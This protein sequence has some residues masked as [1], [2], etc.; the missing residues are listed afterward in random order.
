NID[1]RLAQGL[2]GIFAFDPREFLL[3][4]FQQLADPFEQTTSLKGGGLAPV[5]EGRPGGLDCE[6]NLARPTALDLRDG[7]AGAG[8][9]HVDGLS[10]LDVDSTAV[11]DR[12]LGAVVRVPGVGIGD[13]H[14]SCSCSPLR[15]SW[16]GWGQFSDRS[17]LW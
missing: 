5:G 3:A 12:A 2:P 11:D 4:L 1:S 9:K 14:V 17:V 10:V 13:S 16:C 6:V 8:V 7:L 15:Y